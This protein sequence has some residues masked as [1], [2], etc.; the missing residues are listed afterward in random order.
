M[1]RKMCIRLQRFIFFGKNKH[2]SL[3]QYFHILVFNPSLISKA[4]VSAEFAEVC[5]ISLFW[6]GETVM[7]R[8]YLCPDVPVYCCGRRPMFESLNCDHIAKPGP[9]SDSHCKTEWANSGEKEGKY[10]TGHCWALN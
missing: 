9:D 7:S 6:F 1:L 5:L 4:M 8:P 10:I 2:S 3:Q